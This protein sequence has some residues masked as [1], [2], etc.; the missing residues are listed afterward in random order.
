MIGAS[1]I[2]RLLLAGCRLLFAGCVL[3][4]RLSLAGFVFC[5]NLFLILGLT[6][7]VA[8]PITSIQ[9]GS[10]REQ[11]GELMR[12][13]AKEEVEER[14]REYFG[15]REQIEEEEVGRQDDNKAAEK[16]YGM[17]GGV[18]SV[19][20]RHTVKKGETLLEIAE[21]FG[22]NINEVAKENGIRKSA[23]LKR[24][25][26]LNI[27]VVD[28]IDID[29]DD[30]F[31][32][33][34]SWYGKKFHGRKTTNGETYNMYGRTAAHKTLPFGTML[35][36]THVKNE[37]SVLV[38]INDRGPFIKGRDLDLSFGAANKLGMLIDGV[39]P[40]K[41]KILKLGEEN[42]K[43]KV[44]AKRRGKAALLFFPKRILSLR[45]L[46]YNRYL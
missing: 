43:V 15:D 26:K 7:L 8:F 25:Q 42:K 6:G 45:Y 12:R 29:G 2:K 20:Y 4:K 37:R 28:E 21:K 17:R 14:I 27:T 39:A 10:I 5:L 18:F 41:I 11:V 30:Y 33:I 9:N 35:L 3:I 34:A 36:V 32:L 46:W 31:T 40:L 22:A 19:T 44:E 16:K 13:L 1:L 24:G 38:R 23:S